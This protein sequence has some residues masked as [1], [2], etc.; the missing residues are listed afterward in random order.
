MNDFEQNQQQNNVNMVVASPEH[1]LQTAIGFFIE[2]GYEKV[3]FEEICRKAGVSEESLRA[4]Y[5]DKAALFT[6]SMVQMM[7]NIRRYTLLLLEREAPLREKLIDIVEA[8]LQRPPVDHAGMMKEATPAL[9]DQQL[10]ELKAAE[11]ALH[12]A[13]ADTFSKEMKA[14]GIY[15][16]NPLLAAHSFAAVM[17]TGKHEHLSEQYEDTRA[18]AKDIVELFWYGMSP[19]PD[20]GM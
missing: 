2:Y 1:L 13:V 16:T 3:S 7:V 17:K 4:F 11:R 10:N 20:E 14:G 6:A 18:L 19:L 5:A 9:S 12:K 15:V 8:F